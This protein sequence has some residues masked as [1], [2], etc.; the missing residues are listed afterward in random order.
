MRYALNPESV[1]LAVNRRDGVTRAI[2][3]PASGNDPFAGWGAA[4]QLGEGILLIR[5]RIGLFGSI[6]SGSAAFVGGS[7]G[8]VIQ[9]MRRGLSMAMGYD[10]RRYRPGP[11]DYSHQDLAALEDYL[12]S[13]APLVLTVHRAAEIHEAVA[14]AEDFERQLIIVGGHRGLEGARAARRAGGSGG[15]GRAR[16]HAGDLRAARRA[17]RQRG[18]AA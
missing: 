13:D 12:G 14:L 16:Q 8:A 18:V 10:A 6:D 7:R 2:V 5:E 3:A 1:V 15:G 17:A 4:V 9:R 11:G